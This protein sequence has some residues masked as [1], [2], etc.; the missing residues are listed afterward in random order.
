MPPRRVRRQRSG[1]LF[2]VA[3]TRPA[4]ASTGLQTG[5][6]RPFPEEEPEEPTHPQPQAMKELATLHDRQEGSEELFG[7]VGKLGGCGR[8]TTCRRRNEEDDMNR[9]LIS[10]VFL[11]RHISF[12]LAFDIFGN[13]DLGKALGHPA[14]GAAGLRPTI[15]EPK[16]LELGAGI[17]SNC[18][19]SA[20][21]GKIQRV[22][23]YVNTSALW[24]ALAN[25]TPQPPWRVSACWTTTTS[26]PSPRRAVYIFVT[27]GLLAQMRNEAE[28]AGGAWR[29]RCRISA[30]ALPGGDQE[31]ARH[32]LIAE[33]ADRR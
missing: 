6:P 4:G 27:K 32:R 26:T 19:R 33:F 20:P 29:T 2:N 18:W 15:D 3:A 16:E 1:V 31:G 8:S 21:A 9:K 28:L 30:Q 22:Q 23:K 10:I 12:A 13:I 24:L 14:E 11:M 17:A 25:R 5:V 7:Q